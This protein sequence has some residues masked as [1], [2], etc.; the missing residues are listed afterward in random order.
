MPNPTSIMIFAAGKGTRMLP[1]TQH[2]PKP[3]IA[4][5]GKALLDHAMD[6]IPPLGPMRRVVNLHYKSAMIRNHLSGQDI[7]FSDETDQ[8]LETGGGLRHALPLLGTDPVFTLNTDAVWRGANPLQQLAKAW[9]PTQM[10]ALLLLIKQENA[11]GHSGQGDFVVDQNG[12]LSRGPGH[13]YSGAQIIK[14]DGL[15]DITDTVFSLNLLWDKML[16]NTRLFGLVSDTSWCD[17]GKPSSLPLASAMLGK[18][19]V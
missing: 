19:H 10:D 2:Q 16:K 4:V 3:L 6:L 13:I 7:Q 9:D 18:P 8:L 5:E 12:R 15:A 1:L 14:T 17:V 11:I